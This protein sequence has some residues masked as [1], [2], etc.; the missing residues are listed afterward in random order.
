MPLREGIYNAAELSQPARAAL[1]TAW[2]ASKG[3]NPER[4]VILIFGGSLGSRVMNEVVATALPD[5]QR[6]QIQIIHIVGGK[7]ELPSP[8]EGYLPLSYLNDMASALISA[9][10]VISRS[11]AVTCAELAALGKFALLIPLEIG[12][13]EQKYNASV[14]E[15]AGLAI[16]IANSAFTEHYLSANLI[17]LL[18]H[19]EQVAIAPPDLS[20]ITHPHAVAAIG[21]AAISIAGGR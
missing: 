5:L 9:D 11:G 19:A 13:G 4:K 3:L 8:S 21:H 1:R 16:S 14:L 12:N 20:D 15:K 2:L 7:N 10:L 18:K 17:K 6:A